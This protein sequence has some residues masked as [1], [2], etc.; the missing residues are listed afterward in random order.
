[1][2]LSSAQETIQTKQHPEGESEGVKGATAKPPCRRRSGETPATIK[3]KKH[4]S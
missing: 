2:Y 1:V 3:I 4:H